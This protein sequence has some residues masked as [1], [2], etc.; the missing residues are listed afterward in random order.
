MRIHEDE[1]WEVV[2]QEA[3]EKAEL[4]GLLYV[5]DRLPEGIEEC[6]FINLTS[7]EGYGDSHFKV[8]IPEKLPIAEGDKFRL[9]QLFQNLISN[10]VKFNDKDKGRIEIDVQDQKS[11]Y[12]FSIKWI[13]FCN[14]V[15]ASIKKYVYLF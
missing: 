10:A 4:E 15:V 1:F 6:T 11:F 5:I 8:I 3:E 2:K 13:I 14:S 7:D 12:Q 9:H